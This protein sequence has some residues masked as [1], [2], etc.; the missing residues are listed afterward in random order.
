VSDA[1]SQQTSVAWSPDELRLAIAS[2]GLSVVDLGTG[3]ITNLSRFPAGGPAWS[4]R[5]TIAFTSGA[6][7]EPPGIFVIEPDGHGLT[8]VAAIGMRPV[9]AWSPDGRHLLLDQA[10]TGDFGVLDPT[11]AVEP[12]PLASGRSPA[13][14]PSFP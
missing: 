7:S 3:A 4:P 9:L 2:T 13:W 5:G 8:E 11:R 6:G 10:S 14:Q 12:P 1:A